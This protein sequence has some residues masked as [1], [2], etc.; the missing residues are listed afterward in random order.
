MTIGTYPTIQAW[1]STLFRVTFVAGDW[2]SNTGAITGPHEFWKAGLWLR[3]N[4][5]NGIDLIGRAHQLVMEGYKTMFNEAGNFSS[6]QL[7]WAPTVVQSA[8]SCHCV[9]RAKLLLSVPAW[10]W[11][12]RNLA[13]TNLFLEWFVS[14]PSAMSRLVLVSPGVEMLRQS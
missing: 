7:P 4:H 6:Q 14:L 11:S 9:V 1:S 2:V 13:K 5:T 8:G 10:I 3:F 12:P